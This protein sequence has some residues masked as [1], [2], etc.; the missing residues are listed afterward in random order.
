[1]NKTII[2]TILLFCFCRKIE[3]QTNPP[4]TAE[5]IIKGSIKD[6]KGKPVPYASVTIKDEKYG[7]NT[8]S[9]GVFT[10]KAKLNS[11]LIIGS[12]GFKDIEINIGTK[13][14]ILIVLKRDQQ[15]LR[16]VSV[17]AKSENISGRQPTIAEQQIISNTL[18]DF[19]MS[20]NISS[21]PSV[22][23]SLGTDNNGNPAIVTSFGYS[24]GSGKYYTGAAIPVF[25]PKDATRGRQY[26]FDTWVKGS[27]ITEKGEQIKN[28]RYLFNYDK[29]G[30]NLLL[31]QDEQ[32]IIEVDMMDIGGFTLSDKK[33]EFVFKKIMVAGKVAFFQLLSAENTNYQLFK[34]IMTKLVK[35]NYV[36]NGLTENGNN[37][38]EFIDEYKYIVI[39]TKEKKTVTIELKKKSIKSV[40]ETEKTK[41]DTWLATHN[42]AIVDELF[43]INFVNY[44]NK[45]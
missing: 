11:I 21:A 5:E 42:D 13:S 10:L 6:E 12:V 45:E 33:E 29:M 22:F 37:Y 23:S 24:P 27:V 25:M 2:F 43:L 16:D 34:K 40:F 35:A 28:D 31:T 18:R 44:L 26:L 20:G 8:D 14:E 9:L 7:T 39:F 30:K 38:D 1:M 17:S 19:T 15:S 4:I 32:N 36:N 3:A 41:L